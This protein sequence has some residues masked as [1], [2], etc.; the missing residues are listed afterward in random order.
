MDV[1]ND[2][3][4]VG[5]A[6]GLASTVDDGSGSFGTSWK[7]YRAYQPS[8]ASGLT[9]AYPNP[10][11]PAAEPV[12]IHYGA[13]SNA[14]DRS[15]TIDIFDFGMNRVRTLIQGATRTGLSEYDEIWDGKNDNGKIV[16]NGV[17]IYRLQISGGDPSFG[18]ILLLQ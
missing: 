3:V 16:A 7:I 15:V 11:S 1:L 14:V 8:G 4:F 12:R 13:S 10:F 9:Y 5:T 2:T 18:K 17:Y 6:D